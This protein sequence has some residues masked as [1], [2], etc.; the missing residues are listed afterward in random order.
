MHN[1]DKGGTIASGTLIS[2]LQSVGVVGI[3]TAATGGIALGTGLAVYGGY[4]LYE[5]SKSKL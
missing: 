4:K 3:G 2:T 1:K 5:K